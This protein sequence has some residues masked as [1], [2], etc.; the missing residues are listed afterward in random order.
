MTM[1]APRTA[2]S[3]ISQTVTPSDARARARSPVRFQTRTGRPARRMLLAMPA[4]MMP[5][6]SSA[7]V[8]SDPACVVTYQA[9]FPK[10]LAA[11]PACLTFRVTFPGG[12]RANRAAAPRR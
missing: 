3:A 6:P 4:P 2:S 7:T 12:V 11:L 1:S 8:G 9:P 10:T 5:V